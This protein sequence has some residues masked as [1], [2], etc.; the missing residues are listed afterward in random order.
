[1][2]RRVYKIIF[3]FRDEGTRRIR[4]WVWISS[5]QPKNVLFLAQKSYKGYYRYHKVYP[6]IELFGFSNGLFQ[7]RFST[8]EEKLFGYFVNFKPFEADLETVQARIQD[9][10]CQN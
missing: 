3:G 2:D 4:E 7:H 6:Y 8:Q 1:M 5:F 10:F 9:S